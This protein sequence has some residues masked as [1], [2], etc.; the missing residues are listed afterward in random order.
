MEK[1]YQQIKEYIPYNPQE[2]ADKRLMLQFMEN[3][4]DC[5]ERTNLT[6]HFA[7]TAWVVNK[8]RTKVLMVYHNIY[9]LNTL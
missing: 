1:L 3:N 7:T 6:A 9:K 4:P 8:Q 5:L 2:A